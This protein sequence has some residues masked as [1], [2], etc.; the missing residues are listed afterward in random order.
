[1]DQCNSNISN[2]IIEYKVFYQKKKQKKKKIEARSLFQHMM[3]GEDS[4]AGFF[5]FPSVMTYKFYIQ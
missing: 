2:Q 3:G 1:M 4:P 5:L